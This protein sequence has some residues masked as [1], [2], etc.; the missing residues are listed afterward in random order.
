MR[1]LSLVMS[2]V[3]LAGGAVGCETGDSDL[4]A[5]SPCGNGHIDA[6]EECDL[7]VGN[8]DNA[9]CTS[10]C[11]LA[12][13]GDG[14]V[15]LGVESCDDADTISNGEGSCLADCS[16]IQFC[17]DGDVEGT[18]ECDDAAESAACNSDCTTAQ[19]G[20]AVVNPSAGELCDDGDTISNG[21]GSCLAD[22]SGVQICGDGET[23]G[24]EECDDTV[25]SMTCN[26]DCTA[27][28]CGDGYVNEIAE[29]CDDGNNDSCIGDC[30]VDCQEGVAISGCEDGVACGTEECDDGNDVDGDGC[31]SSCTFVGEDVWRFIAG[32]TFMMGSPAGVGEDNEHPQHRVTVAPFRIHRT[33]VTR[34]Q[35]KACVDA[36]ICHSSADCYEV[37]EWDMDG[38]D[39]DPVNC[40]SWFHA[41]EY[42]EWLGA[43]LPTEAEWEYAARSRGRDVTYPW[44]D[45]A[46]TCSRVVVD[47]G[48]DPVHT[49]PVCSR[50]TGNTEQGLCDM[51]GNVYELVQDSRHETY[52]G[53][54]SDGSA[55][56]DP[57]AES[58]V[59]RGGS[60][61]DGQFPHQLAVS[62][63][64]YVEPSYEADAIG[65]RCVQPVVP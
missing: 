40:V 37:A 3:W 46:P 15:L 31:S 50:P 51:S 23:E 5:P 26:I 43:R 60:W 25:E 8:S 47:D 55:W 62:A 41:V 13:C 28:E 10:A 14:L 61:W 27:T 56:T 6:G 29:V 45:E 9:M 20:D 64:C 21:E 36:G 42:C 53:A 52:D 35:Y 57:I 24:T 63:R 4:P 1:A 38:R 18:E 2:A 22:C 11:R 7:G 65:F 32:G 34:A 58:I 30:R 48:C 19:C 12:R 54:P 16:G 44:G 39:N 59:V 33:E 49:A 17:G